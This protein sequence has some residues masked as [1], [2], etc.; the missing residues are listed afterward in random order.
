MYN[1][2]LI[3][4]GWIWVNIHIFILDL[5]LFDD[6]GAR[7]LQYI[8]THTC[9]KF[10]CN[11]LQVRQIIVLNIVKIIYLINLYRNKCKHDKTFV[12]YKLQ[13]LAIQECDTKWNPYTFTETN[14]FD[15]NNVTSSPV[16]KIQGRQSRLQINN[17]RVH[18]RFSPFWKSSAKNVKPHFS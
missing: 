14:V 5:Q 11:Y 2:T 7:C 18:L 4:K 16:M 12:C 6:L 10:G 1:H 9:I 3:L 13:Q 15:Q 8:C 17:Q